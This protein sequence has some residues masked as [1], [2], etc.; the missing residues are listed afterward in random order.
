[1]SEAGLYLPVSKHSG[2]KK[3]VVPSFGPTK[4]LEPL[5]R[6]AAKPKSL[7][8]TRWPLSA[9][10]MLPGFTSPRREGQHMPLEVILGRCPGSVD[11]LK[12]VKMLQST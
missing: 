4:L 7:S 9:T 1:M 6:K 11:D 12:A 8:T 10:K 3:P 2:A 5:G